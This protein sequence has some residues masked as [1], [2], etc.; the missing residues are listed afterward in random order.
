MRGIELEIELNFLAILATELELIDSPALEKS[1][2]KKISGITNTTPGLNTLDLTFLLTPIYKAHQKIEVDYL[3]RPDITS[4]QLDNI[5]IKALKRLQLMSKRKKTPAVLLGRIK[6]ATDKITSEASS[7]RFASILEPLIIRKNAEETAKGLSLIAANLI[8][9]LAQDDNAEDIKN[10][11]Y[12]AA[13]SFADALYFMVAN[14]L[15]SA[16]KP[17]VMLAFWISVLERAHKLAD[18]HSILAILPA[19]IEFNQP[20]ESTFVMA[21]IDKK[22]NSAYQNMRMLYDSISDDAASSSKKYKLSETTSPHLGSIKGWIIGEQEIIRAEEKKDAAI[23]LIKQRVAAVSLKAE[24]HIKKIEHPYAD[25]MA[26]TIKNLLIEPTWS[27]AK[28]ISNSD[29]PQKTAR[30]LETASSSLFFQETK[31]TKSH[32]RSISEQAEPRPSSSNQKN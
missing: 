5:A 12:L 2:L 8:I 28:N 14:D 23:G 17:K 13:V 27:P 9:N 24:E 11:T 22:L 25:V 1:L 6:A 31:K 32:F 19:L 4:A 7:L 18:T 21:K 15:T 16:E 20:V 3:P 26:T 29:K 30:S 10:T